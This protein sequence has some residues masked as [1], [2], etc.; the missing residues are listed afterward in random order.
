MKKASYISLLFFIA[1]LSILSLP[2]KTSEP[3]ISKLS[4]D[5]IKDSW[6]FNNNHSL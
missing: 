1:T 2:E 6:V 3:N 4:D 5:E